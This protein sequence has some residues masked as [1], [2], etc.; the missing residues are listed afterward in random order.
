VVLVRNWE[1]YE[2]SQSAE[3][4]DSRYCS[5]PCA[6]SFFEPEVGVDIKGEALTN[7][8]RAKLDRIAKRYPPDPRVEA[9]QAKF[10]FKSL[11]LNPEG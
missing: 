3:S 6:Q 10:L 11:R 8:L 2:E 4:S 9:L 1:A 5:Y 7:I